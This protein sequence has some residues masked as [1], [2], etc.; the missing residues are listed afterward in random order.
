MIEHNRRRDQFTLLQK[1]IC[2]CLDIA[3]IRHV[4]LILHEFRSILRSVSRVTRMVDNKSESQPQRA[5]LG[6]NGLKGTY[7]PVLGA[8]KGSKIFLLAKYALRAPST[9]V[10]LFLFLFV[11]ELFSVCLIFTTT[12]A[13]QISF[14]RRRDLSAWAP[15]RTYVSLSTR[16]Y[17]SNFNLSLNFPRS[18]LRNFNKT[19]S[20]RS[21]L[22]IGKRNYVT[23]LHVMI[24]FNIYKL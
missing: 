3:F 23:T 19:V 5:S 11:P 10:F 15:K 22:E 20:Q 17:L 12:G 8:N 1:I 14:T 21:I 7:L 16:E 2:L 13:I 18:W 4:K 9:R 6:P 24:I